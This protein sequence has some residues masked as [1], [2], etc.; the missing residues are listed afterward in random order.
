MRFAP[1]GNEKLGKSVFV[2]S[3]PVGDTCPADCYFLH[4]GCYAEATEKRFPN[5]RDAATL[6]LR[7]SAQEL[8]SMILEAIRL[9]KSIRIHERGDFVKPHSQTPENP[10]GE[11][12]HPYLHAWRSAIRSI[13]KAQRPPI[14]C[15]THHY[16]KE[17]LVLARLGVSVYASVS[18]DADYERAKTA[19]FKLF[20]FTH[21]LTK[22]KKPAKEKIGSYTENEY[23]GRTLVCPEQRMGR[24]T[25]TCDKC[26]WC[27]HG[28][29]NIVFLTH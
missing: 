11:L 25:V 18:C 19:G 4:N 28:K 7:V 26:K 2:V 5:A 10:Q 23:A 17:I 8:R 15:Y 24:A 6:N 3:R 29:G 1:K 13:P 27:I 12:D 22:G 21:E 16:S 20:A 14:W 9:G